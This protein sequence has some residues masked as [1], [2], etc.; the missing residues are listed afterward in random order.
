MIDQTSLERA[1]ERF[2]PADGSF[3]RLVV[4]RR[5]RARNRKLASGVVSAVVTVASITG[6]VRAFRPAEPR[7]GDEPRLDI[8][9][10]VH[11]WIAYGGPDGIWAIDPDRPSDPEARVQLSVIPGEPIAWSSDGSALLVMRASTANGT[12]ADV[13]SRDPSLLRCLSVLRADATETKVVP[14]GGGTDLSRGYSLSPDGSRVASVKVRPDSDFE[15]I[16]VFDAEGGR[17]QLLRSTEMEPFVI[18]DLRWRGW[19]MWP[20]WSPDATQIA[21]FHGGGDHSE[22]LKVMDAEGTN[23]HSLFGDRRL[24]GHV[25]GLTWS[26][27]GSELAFATDDPDG[28][29]GV[30][31]IGA[32]GSGYRRVAVHGDDPTWSPDGSRLAFVL[33]GALFTVAGDG[34]DVR[35]IRDVGAGWIAWN[36]LG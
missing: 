16:Y 9:A 23:A 22:D 36:P 18:R 2:Q 33:G 12:P 27:D 24:Q 3:E 21:Y 10:G 34:S 20:A 6:L 32:D 11:G 8:F 25:Q 13:R 26:P 29:L 1:T 15:G 35:L 4:R 7:M 30:W 5:G 31:I 14:V 28:E 17:P 19:L